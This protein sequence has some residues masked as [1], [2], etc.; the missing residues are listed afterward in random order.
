MERVLAIVDLWGG[1]FSSINTH[2][3]FTPAFSLCQGAPL[4]CWSRQ[5][6]RT[7]FTDSTGIRSYFRG[8]P[9]SSCWWSRAFRC[10]CFGKR[11][12]GWCECLSE[13][14]GFEQPPARALEVVE[15]SEPTQC[16]SDEEWWS[17]EDSGLWSRDFLFRRVNSCVK[18]LGFG[19]CENLLASVVKLL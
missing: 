10:S 18:I 6:V 14:E 15:P 4:S 9:D 3:H 8:L 16:S 19:S 13:P 17:D 5:P 1:W 11:T 7:L 12:S 2:R